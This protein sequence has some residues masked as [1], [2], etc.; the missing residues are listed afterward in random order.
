MKVAYQQWVHLLKRDTMR[1]RHVINR[2]SQAARLIFI[3]VNYHGLILDLAIAFTN[4]PPGRLL[5]T[6]SKK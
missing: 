1:G 4:D 6:V 5:S 3:D 2:N